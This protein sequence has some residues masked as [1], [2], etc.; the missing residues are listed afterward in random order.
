MPNNKFYIAENTLRVR[1]NDFDDPNMV[2]MSTFG[3]CTIT[4][5]DKRD[6]VI[7]VGTPA[8]KFPTWNVIALNIKFSFPLSSDV[9]LY[10]SLP[11]E[12]VT[13]YTIL[14]DVRKEDAQG[15]PLF[16][17]QNFYVYVGK[18][19]AV[20]NSKR[21]FIP[22]FG[23]KS[24]DNGGFITDGS[25]TNLNDMFALVK[26]ES[27]DPSTWYVEALRD[28]LH[29]VMR[30]NLKLGGQLV[31]KGKEFTS[32]VDTSTEGGG[33]T[34]H[35]LI[36][37]LKVMR[38]IEENNRLADER[39]LRK[40]QPDQTNHLLKIG[41]FIDSL[42]AGKGTGLFPDGRIQTD[43]MEIRQSLT[44]LRL[45]INEIQGM[46]G[47][48]AFSDCG[49]IE[50]VDKITDTTYK[51][52]MEK[53]TK[54]DFTLLNEDDVLYSIVNSMLT[55]GTDYYT[56]WMRVVTK[57][58]NDNTLTVVL[59]PDSEVPGGRNFPPAEGYNVSRR[60]NAV[61]P[62]A[63]STNERGQS[64]LLSSREG[65]IMFFENV[66]KPILEDYNYSLSI[67]KFPDLK[68][69]KNLPLSKSDTGVYAK[70]LVA[71]RFYQIDHNG[72]VTPAKVDRGEWSAA[73]AQSA[74]PYRNVAHEQLNEAGTT[75]TLLEQHTVY[76]TGCKW[77][78]L[79]DKT[80]DEPIWNSPGWTLI[81]GDKNYHLGFTSSDGFEIFR[82]EVN[83]D[84]AAVVEYGNR[85]ITNLLMNTAGVEIEWLRD[86]KNV[87][88]DNSWRPTFV[89]GQRHV[90]HLSKADMGSDWGLT[91]RKVMFRCRI[92]IP[93]GEDKPLELGNY[94]GFKL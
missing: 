18:L 82:R 88:A 42:L 25:S 38:A 15:R 83:T 28:L 21:T 74:S 22:D 17:G 9:Y 35:Q 55:G 23:V 79:I 27:Q 34:D 39:Y 56:S 75:F 67:G 11:R 93:V 81:E 52:W 84:I 50:K 26:P 43:R 44:V 69:F 63:G 59:Y 32:V 37:A 87:P 66:Y 3:I 62:D 5:Y 58:L 6:G 70:N 57:N 31:W 86:T 30:G 60:G 40:D 65:R 73:I 85:D 29:L 91:V 54:T 76:H 77:A 49:C 45:I 4:Y 2:N 94:I 14:S 80:L 12:G 92:F 90:I 72:D 78:C 47:D 13:A 36:T 53:R 1:P 71:E 20:E 7:Q 51:L 89:N 46:S 10:L 33:Y 8:N 48:F 64:W 16:D 24:T 19:T 61:I 68:A 41:E